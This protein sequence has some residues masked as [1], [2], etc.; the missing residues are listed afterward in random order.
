MSWLDMSWLDH[1]YQQ[2]HI[3]IDI[4]CVSDYILLWSFQPHALKWMVFHHSCPSGRFLKSPI[5]VPVSWYKWCSTIS[6]CIGEK[7]KGRRVSF[8]THQINL[9]QKTD[10]N[11]NLILVGVCFLLQIDPRYGQL[12]IFHLCKPKLWSSIYIKRQGQWW[13]SLG[14]SQ[15]YMND[16]TLL[17]WTMKAIGVLLFWKRCQIFLL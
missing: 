11:Y 2:K 9:D 4:Y 1:S 5:F 8:N 10:P 14:T 6:A 17:I 12:V 3:I 16:E 15:M 7:N 13:V